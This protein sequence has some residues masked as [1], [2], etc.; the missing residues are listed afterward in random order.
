M[1]QHGFTLIE[2]L[3]VLAIT[4]VLATAGFLNLTSF[5]ASRSVRAHLEE[6][7][8]AI[9][10][11]RERSRTQEEG[12]SWGMRFSNAPNARQYE[13]FRGTSYATGESMREYR[14]SPPVLF[15]EPR[16][17]SVFEL[18][19][20]P[21]TGELPNAKIVSFVHPGTPSLVGDVIVGALG[22]VSTR[23]HNEVF[24]YWHFD[25]GAGSSALDATT[26][27]HAATLQNGTLWNPA[28][29][30]GGCISLD[31]ADDYLS[32]NFQG[33]VSKFTVM[34][35][36]NLT[37]FGNF[38]ALF[39]AY[40]GGTGVLYGRF[41]STSRKPSF[42]TFPING[43]ADELTPAMQIS[44]YEW[45]HMAYV[46]DGVMKRI[47][48][49]GEEIASAPLSGAT[50][51]FSSFEI[52]RSESMPGKVFQGLLDEVRFYGR[53]I[54]PAEVRDAYNELR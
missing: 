38:G 15:S 10:D 32:G 37:G 31:G 47:Y 48:V 11:A 17:G 39:S 29:K 41:L 20:S 25:D 1:K 9:L 44:L 18:A 7:E 52:G 43:S 51:S 54:G 53:A 23:L 22:G 36:V 24:G 21:V 16:A 2:V 3:I 28:C 40:S 26:F 8:S 33:E 14:L 34:G 46:Y 12:Y 5:R 30:A 45:H 49:D 50:F 27:G 19:F 6:A 4:G 35:W 13:L 42:F